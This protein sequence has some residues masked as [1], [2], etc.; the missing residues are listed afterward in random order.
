[1]VYVCC[2]LECFQPIARR[3]PHTKIKMT[4]NTPPGMTFQADFLDNKGATLLIVLIVFGKHS[5][6]DGFGKIST[7]SIHT[8]K[9]TCYSYIQ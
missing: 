5:E 3:A 8:V 7:N 1:M 4:D 2:N 9:R 6:K